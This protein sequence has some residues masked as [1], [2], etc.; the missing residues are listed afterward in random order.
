MD[1]SELSI[2]VV[3]AVAAALFVHTWRKL[4]PQ[5][6]EPSVS[7]VVL[8][9]GGHTA[10]MLQLLRG[11]LPSSDHSSKRVYVVAKTD[12]LSAEKA[13][14]FEASLSDSSKGGSYSIEL[15]DRAREVGQSYL[16]SVITTMRSFLTTASL[17]RRH[18]PGMVLVNGPGTCLPIVVWARLLVAGCL[19]YYVESIARVDHLSLTGKILLR[20]RLANGGFFV[21]WRELAESLRKQG[22]GNGTVQFAGRVY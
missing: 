13:V 2:R 16:T 9:S 10:E 22:H 17:V 19:V 15:V 11:M 21:Q 18:R 6:R 14:A 12:T 7:L 5:L 4:R 1:G 20:L 3:L 8:G